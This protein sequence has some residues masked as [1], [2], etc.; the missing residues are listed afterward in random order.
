MEA[1]SNKEFF[2]NYKPNSP[3]TQLSWDLNVRYLNVRYLNDTNN[4]PLHSL[5]PTSFTLPSQT[6]H[7]NLERRILTRNQRR[8]MRLLII[9]RLI[10]LLPL[11]F[12]EQPQ[13]I[14][15][16]ENGGHFGH[17][18]EFLKS[19][20]ELWGSFTILLYSYFWSY[21]EKFSLL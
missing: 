15:F 11:T 13:N 12:L 20:R 5:W 7:L 10:H 6:G 18:L 21:A 16:L 3:W 2:I 19:S 4:H 8:M 9:L 17:R 14:T 1:G